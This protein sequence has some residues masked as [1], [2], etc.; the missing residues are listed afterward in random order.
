MCEFHAF[1]PN[2]F[3]IYDVCVKLFKTEN[4]KKTTDMEEN[5]LNKSSREVHESRI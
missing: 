3:K 2:S 4:V 1:K 5:M